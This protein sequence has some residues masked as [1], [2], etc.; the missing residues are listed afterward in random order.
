MTFARKNFM[1]YRCFAGKNATDLIRR[2]HKINN[3][4]VTVMD[5]MPMRN[6]V[7]FYVRHTRNSR[8]AIVSGA[9]RIKCN[10]R[11]AHPTQ[12]RVELVI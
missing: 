1:M 8:E 2:N 6:V 11:R 10:R 5:I 3:L 4:H 7:R 12:G 9:R